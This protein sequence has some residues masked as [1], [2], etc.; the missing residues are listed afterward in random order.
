MKSKKTLLKLLMLFLLTAS[1]LSC[2][3][4]KDTTMPQTLTVSTF[5]GSG[6]NG[7]TDGPAATAQFTNPMGLTTD[8]QGNVY[9]TSG[10]CIKKITLT[11][12][13]S[14]LAGVYNASGY[15]D[16]TT[17]VARFNNPLGLTADAQGNIYVADY[18][19]HCI[20]KITPAGVVTTVAGNG[21]LGNA[22]GNGSTA[23]FYYPYDVAF[24]AT[25]T[26]LFVADTYNARIRKI[27]A[28]S[29][30]STYAGS[31]PGFADGNVSSA[32]FNFIT[33][34]AVD[35][36]GNL[37][38]CDRNNYR[39]RKITASGNV[40]TIAGTGATGLANGLAGNATFSTFIRELEV[41]DNGNVYIADQNNN[42]IRKIAAGEVTIYAGS[43]VQG[44]A[45]GNA[46]TAEFKVPAG[47]GISGS[48]VYVTD[49]G[50]YRVR[51][52]ALQ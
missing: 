12:Q 37:Y 13:V 8:A 5:A 41:D 27:D 7:D 39:I 16:A 15:I 17:T 18:G 46:S 21:T 30:V 40:I 33:G 11:G 52:I 4:N 28:G 1:L 34:I 32:L 26:S 35:K 36:Q 45:D 23:R 6:I 9:V 51:K 10:Q 42:C 38:V 22:N 20:R 2:K 24:D 14:T 25:T 29:N 50:N 49:F 31:T 47:L 19:N 44:F 3:K 43:S 48:T